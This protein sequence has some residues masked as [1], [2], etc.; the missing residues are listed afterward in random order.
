M[1]SNRFK[2]E[3]KRHKSKVNAMKEAL[4]HSFSAISSSSVTTIV[5]LL[6][7]VF[8]SFTIGRDLGF[9]LAKGVLLS[10]ISIFA[11]YQHYYFFAM[12]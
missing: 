10:L 4:Y 2:Q 3:K 1:L 8:M 12:T 6:A 11:A 9:V 7:L 5:G